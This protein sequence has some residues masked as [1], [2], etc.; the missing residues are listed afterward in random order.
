MSLLLDTHIFLWAIGAPLQLPPA[1]ADAL[2]SPSNRRFFS[3]A[4][5]WEIGIKVA[6]GRLNFPVRELDGHLGR[7]NLTDV[8]M[9]IE[10]C[11]A[12]A[13]L[14]RHHGDPFDRMLVAQA[15]VEGLTLVTL[16]S[17]LHQYDVPIFGRLGVI[18]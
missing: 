17:Q 18:H 13:A 5:A 16:D 15:K 10:H 14:P 3:A 4:S 6:A 11:L 1:I 12:A 7:L 2:R 9:T 8:P